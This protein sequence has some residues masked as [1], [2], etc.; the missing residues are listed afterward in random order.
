M[1]SSQASGETPMFGRERGLDHNAGNEGGCREAEG[2][3]HSELIPAR[4]GKEVMYREEKEG[5]C[6]R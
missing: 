4:R 6:I 1:P 3:S 2:V 5:N